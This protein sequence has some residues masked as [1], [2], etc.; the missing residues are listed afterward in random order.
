MDSSG[1]SDIGRRQELTDLLEQ[2]KALQD[3]L[4]SPSAI[5]TGAIDTELRDLAARLQASEERLKE[6]KPLKPR[7]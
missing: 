7:R 3:R 2:I 1:E 5:D 4:Q 6:R